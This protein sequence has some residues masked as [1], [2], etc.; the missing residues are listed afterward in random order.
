MPFIVPDQGEVQMLGILLGLLPPEA[1]L[2]LRLYVNDYTPTL[3]DT[4]ASYEE[5]S[6]HG[7][8]RLSVPPA[9]WGITPAQPGK[10]TPALARG[11]RQTFVFSIA[12]PPVLVYGYFFVTPVAGRVW[13]AER[14]ADGP[15]RVQN[16]NDEIS[17][18]PEFTTRSE[19]P[20]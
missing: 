1:A 8:A 14:F 7:Y 13:A 10:N 2:D 4:V 3:T 18:E 5:M 12:G 9:A 11:A 20:L 17:V 16:P 6:T 19:Y 15:Y